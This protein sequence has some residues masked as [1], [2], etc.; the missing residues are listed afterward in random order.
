VGMVIK[1]S[2]P[3]AIRERLSLLTSI[4]SHRSCNGANVSARPMQL[5]P[6]GVVAPVTASL[7]PSSARTADRG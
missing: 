7:A 4:S 1:A 2:A 5:S 3:N 6:D